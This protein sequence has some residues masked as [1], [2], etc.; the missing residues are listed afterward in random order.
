MGAHP[1][2]FRPPNRASLYQGPA[3]KVQSLYFQAKSLPSKLG[4][5]NGGSPMVRYSR[6]PNGKLGNGGRRQVLKISRLGCDESLYE[7]C[8][9][10]PPELLRE[11]D[12]NPGGCRRRGHVA[13]TC[14]AFECDDQSGLA[15]LQH[16]SIP[17]RTR[18][19]AV[20]LPVCGN[21]K[22]CATVF[23]SCPLLCVGV[24]T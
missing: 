9:V 18:S 7:R 10:V 23:L 19:R 4:T 12:A 21:A 14:T 8:L 6:I 20:L 16:Q 22:R 2:S 24:S 3:C 5:E 1:S 15:E 13:C 17:D 11:Q